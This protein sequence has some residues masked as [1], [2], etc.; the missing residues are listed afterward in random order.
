MRIGIDLDGVC[1]DFTNSLRYYLVEYEGFWEEDLTPSTCWDFYQ[2]DWGLTFDEYKKYTDEGVDA[3]VVFLYGDTL[4]GAI[5]GLLSLKQA[6]HTLHACTNR[7]FGTKAKENTMKWLER[8]GLNNIFDT[9]TFS[10][11]KTII[12]VDVFIDDYVGNY[13]ELDAA[14][15]DVVLL[16]QP[17]NEHKQDAV[18]VPSWGDF[19]AYVEDKRWRETNEEPFPYEPITEEAQ[20]LVYGNR[21]A[22]YGHPYDD[23]V[24]TARLWSA[25]LGADVT[26]QK[27][28]LCMIAVKMSRLVNDPRKRDSI[29]DIA[30]YAECLSRSNRRE[31]GLE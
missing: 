17:W 19:V 27:A 11:D 3:G 12:N 18:R 9:V 1:Y 7:F 21:N 28:I 16:T 4:P 30:G 2:V 20:R 23:Y 8:T 29:V 26:P 22:D 15:V 5:D 25:I 24:R 14:G 31:D 10:K 6:G 13:E